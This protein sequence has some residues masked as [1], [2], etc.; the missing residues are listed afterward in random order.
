[1]A[2]RDVGRV[3]ELLAGVGLV[4]FGALF[5]LAQLAGPRGWE[6]VWPLFV[7]VIGALLLAG[8]VALG[9]DA[10][11]LAIP[12][13]IIVGGGLLLLVTNTLDIWP[14]WAYLWALLT[15]GSVGVGLWLFGVWSG[16]PR[17]RTVG[18]WLT[19]AGIVLAAVLG[20]V[21]ELTLSL[22]G[23]GGQ[24]AARILGPVLLVLAGVLMLLSSARNRIKYL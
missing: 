7:V 5:L 23:P 20:V 12:G 24:A 18:L 19:V 9:R 4:A 14:A 11:F 16:Y 2:T 13:C 17:T 21:F 6:L 1:M 10:G 3:V 22:T 15:P 8:M